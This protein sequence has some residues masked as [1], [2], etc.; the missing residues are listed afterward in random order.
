LFRKK[1][2]KINFKWVNLDFLTN[3]YN[4]TR[5][6][7]KMII[8]PKT[9]KNNKW[10]LFRII[11]VFVLHSMCCR[12]C[13]FT[14]KL[15][16]IEIAWGMILRPWDNFTTFLIDQD[17]I[18]RIWALVFNWLYNY[19]KVEKLPTFLSFLLGILNLGSLKLKLA[20]RV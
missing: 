15:K 19:L 1:K 4:F 8:Y 20:N 16:I 14:L 6:F 18:S 10:R 13:V 5:I 17:E 9:E 7:L 11:F 3:Y 2:M 12:Y